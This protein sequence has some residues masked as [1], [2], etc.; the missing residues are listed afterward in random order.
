MPIRITVL[1]D[2]FVARPGRLLGEYGLSL[3]IERGDLRVLYDTGATGEALL[4]NAREMGV[5]LGRLDYIVLSH[6]HSDHTG[7]LMRLLE[8]TGEGPIL[9]AHPD[10]FS[11]ALV[12][13]GGR[14]REIGAPFTEE[15]LRRRGVRPILVRE[16][17]E[18]EEGV[19]V[20]GEIPR[21][22]GPSHA[23]GMFRPEG[24]RIVAD[25]M[26]DDLALYLRADGEF[27]AITGCGHAG[28]ENIVEHGERIAGGRPGAI[29][30][31]LHLLRSED[32]RIEEVAAYLSSKSPR[33]VVPLHCTGPRAHW[34]LSAR[35]GR[36]Y[37]LSGAGDVIEY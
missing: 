3:L 29:V 14:W 21:D 5:D 11:P 6:R 35:L 9:I 30:G 16:P 36:A 19:W 4:R 17:L 1:V 23:W 12:R 10:L 13:D 15:D 8:V 26:M 31:G 22:K 33:L 25:D 32:K 24:G 34:Q 20:S 37:R 28:V 2:N 27:V 7:G 18:L